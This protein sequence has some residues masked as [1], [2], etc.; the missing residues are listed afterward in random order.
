MKWSLKLVLRRLLLN[1]KRNILL[2]IQIFLGAAV[3]FS[4]L[5]IEESCR[6]KSAEYS[7][8]ISS[9]V[10]TINANRSPEEEDLDTGD[11]EYIRD[12]LLPE[13][14]TAVFSFNSGIYIEYNGTEW[15]V[16]VV[17]A[18]EGYMT[19]IAGVAD[20]DPE[21]YYLGGKLTEAFYS[22]ECRVTY[23]EGVYD[24]AAG[25]LFGRPVRD[26]AV[27][28][29]ASTAQ[30]AQD[31]YMN[32]DTEDDLTFANSI[33]LPLALHDRYKDSLGGIAGLYIIPE[34]EN[35]PSVDEVCGRICSELAE[36]HPAVWFTYS[37]DLADLLKFQ[38]DL[39]RNAALF[40]TVSAVMIIILFFE[41]IG[42]FM[43]I[44]FRRQRSFAIARMCGAEA[45]KLVLELFLEIGL[46]A[47]LGALAGI[48]AAALV[49]PS[50][51]SSL[52]SVQGTGGAAAV[53]YGLFLGI[54]AVTVL[55]CV[56]TIVRS[57][58]VN[59]LRNHDE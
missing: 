25:E 7:E 27:P 47:S 12:N 59:I 38:T 5:S 2:V 51:S 34:Q 21:G 10:I 19:A 32:A 3:L 42:Q 4:C 37:N 54:T 56:P 30:M 15:R 48:G 49:V 29:V 55:C 31:A 26:Y 40:K 36:R 45:G 39:L 22:N 57:T 6:R 16:P 35:D 23:G 41:L 11:Y 20:L 43:L 14:Y 24:R 52:Y 50:F 28:D 18:S 1:K 17:F 46:L 8:G 9:Q 53:V 44:A 13:D 58:P 33:I